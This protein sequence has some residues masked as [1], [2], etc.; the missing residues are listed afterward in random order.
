MHGNIDRH[1]TCME[2]LTVFSFLDATKPLSVDFEL[3]ASIRLVYC[4]SKNIQLYLL[5]VQI[6][7]T[8]C[9][10]GP[11]TYN[12]FTVGPKPWYFMFCSSMTYNLM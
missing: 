9:I 1:V 12:L 7:T 8:L 6:P 2:T 11:M 10:V 3:C 5:Q 4:R